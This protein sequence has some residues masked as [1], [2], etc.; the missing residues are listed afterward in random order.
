MPKNRKTKNFKYSHRAT[1]GS[2]DA[3]R[4]S[5]LDD[6]FYDKGDLEA[7]TSFDDYRCIVVGRTGA[8][9]TA[10]IETIKT[11]W[12]EKVIILNP[13]ELSLS[14]ISNNNVIKNYDEAGV[15]LVPFYRQLWKHVLVTEI[16]KKHF[17]IENAAGRERFF[18]FISEF[19]LRNRAKDEAIKYLREWGDNFWETTE[20]RIKEMVRKIT[21]HQGKSVSGS[22]KGTVPGIEGSAQANYE[23]SKETVE[24]QKSEI[25]QKAQ[26]I[27]DEIQISKL[28]TVIKL[29]AE[30]ILTDPQKQYFITIDQLDEDW[31]EDKIRY[32][33]IFE[34]ITTASEINNL[35]MGR[36]KIIIAL[37]ADLLDRMYIYL[38]Q[39]QPLNFQR[40]KYEDL[41]YRITWNASQLKKLLKMR[42]E[43]LHAKQFTSQPITLEEF[44]SDKNIEL[45]EFTVK[46]I[47]YKPLDYILERT[48]Y[49]PR[50]VIRFIN[51]CIEVATAQD[52]G[53]LTETI[54]RIAERSISQEKL[55]ALEG[56]W[57]V[58]YPNL[59]PVC[60][61]LRDQPSTFT[62]REFEQKQ[63]NKIDSVFTQLKQT[64]C[65]FYKLLSELYGHDGPEM[66]IV[67]A[68]LFHI[69]FDIGIVGIE[70]HHNSLVYWSFKE[71]KVVRRDFY[72][73]STM[74][75]IHP[76]FFAALS[77]K[78]PK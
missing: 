18:T 44:F 1:A 38:Q 50:D 35:L 34:L 62:I 5:F 41:Y 58:N 64:N 22:L 13:H 49:I 51:R 46:K 55:N 3:S 68:E 61:L 31:I 8:G 54:I 71:N 59:M 78:T 26:R 23:D 6:C 17:R 15:S 39:N 2:I 52:E 67:L 33:L 20:V 77:I 47:K 37:R 72:D 56:E 70:R 21:T 7:L 12:A 30:N 16:I 40:E 74:I 69:L 73:P 43:H 66:S 75:Y 14:F 27:V 4:D 36:V 42:I 9:K 11:N 65:P 32:R 28:Q 10:L 45:A 60:E 29:L 19:L 24:E 48:M 53:V 25:I 76:V 57:G 63:Q